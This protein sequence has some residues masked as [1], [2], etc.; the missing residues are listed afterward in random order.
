VAIADK[1]RYITVLV[2]GWSGVERAGVIA[3][4]SAELLAAINRL[5]Y[6]AGDERFQRSTQSTPVSLVVS[7]HAAHSRLMELLRART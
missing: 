5:L 6:C 7:A 1:R 2:T 3:G 4:D